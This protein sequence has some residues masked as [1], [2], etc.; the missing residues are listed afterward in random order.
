MIGQ[1]FDAGISFLPLDVVFAGDLIVVPSIVEDAVGL[2]KV[3]LDGVLIA[4]FVELNT[5]PLLR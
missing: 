1:F 2:R 4:V 3:I 5:V